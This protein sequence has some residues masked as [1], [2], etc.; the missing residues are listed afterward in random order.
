[1]KEKKKSLFLT[2]NTSGS[3]EVQHKIFDQNQGQYWAKQNMNWD[4]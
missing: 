1:M 2:K 3:S 4:T